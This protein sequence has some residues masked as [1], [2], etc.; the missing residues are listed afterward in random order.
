MDISNF[1]SIIFKSHTTIADSGGGGSIFGPNLALLGKYKP[2]STDR[3]L[4]NLINVNASPLFFYD[5]PPLA[6][7]MLLQHIRP[8]QFQIEKQTHYECSI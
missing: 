7:D 3:Y 8:R 2:V 1:K 6:G 5:L 4:N